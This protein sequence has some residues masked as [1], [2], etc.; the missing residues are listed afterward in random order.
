MRSCGYGRFD[1]QRDLYIRRCPM[2][3]LPLC[4][5]R[6]KGSGKESR[7]ASVYASSLSEP[8]SARSF[9]GARRCVGE[10]VRIMSPLEYVG[11]QVV[12]KFE[13]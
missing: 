5:S 13:E 1:R 8:F 9:P 7:W 12:S 2:I 11:G 4:L 10:G 6:P 3:V